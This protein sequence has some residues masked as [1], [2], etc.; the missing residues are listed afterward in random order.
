[1][2]NT[3][4]P[5]THPVG[6]GIMP[7]SGERA[8][9]T[10][11][12]AAGVRPGRG[13]RGDGPADAGRTRPSRAPDRR[14][15]RARRV[16]VVRL[17]APQQL[18][19]LTRRRA[20]PVDHGPAP[21]TPAHHLDPR[22]PTASHAQA[23]DGC[24]HPSPEPRPHRRRAGRVYR[25]GRGAATPRRRT[26]PQQQHTR[27]QRPPL[28][29]PAPPTESPSASTSAART[30]CSPRS[31]TPP[32]VQ[33]PCPSHPRPCPAACTSPTPACPKRTGSP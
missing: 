1:M 18:R 19:P 17:R 2:G 20:R 12:V 11:T 9:G 4:L 29:T 13:G 10:R 26:C 3:Q 21:P 33:Q 30:T 7:G 15:R 5:H 28:S 23:D 22:G 31:S 14:Q 27:T 25:H 32:P 16:R 8:T 6:A 24:P